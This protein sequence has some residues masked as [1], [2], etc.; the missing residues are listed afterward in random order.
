MNIAGTPR[1][2]DQRPGNPPPPHQK[3]DDKRDSLQEASYQGPQA[4]GPALCPLGVPVWEPE[5]RGGGQAGSGEDCSQEI[6]H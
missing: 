6:Q 4:G 2:T 3:I 5:A 1:H